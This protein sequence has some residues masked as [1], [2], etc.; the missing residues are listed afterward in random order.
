MEA[1]LALPHLPRP[2]Y[3]NTTPTICKYHAPCTISVYFSKASFCDYVSSG[4]PPTLCDSI[5]RALDR[6][7][8]SILAAEEELKSVLVEA[9][10]DLKEG[11]RGRRKKGRMDSPHSVAQG[12][13]MCL[14]LVA[15]SS[16]AT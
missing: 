12:E 16:D 8:H 2:L 14:L 6:Q 15:C 4:E 7:R 13:E 10:E 5:Q 1:T 11:R 9:E 3:A